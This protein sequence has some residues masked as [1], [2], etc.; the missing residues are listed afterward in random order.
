MKSLIGRL[1]ARG[2][3]L[4]ELLVVIAIIGILAGMLLPAVA[5]ARERARRTRCMSN[6]SQIGKAMKLYSMDHDEAFPT[7]FNPGLLGYDVDNPK[8]YHCPSDRHHQIADEFEDMTEQYCSYNLV[9]ESPSGTA[10][11]EGSKSTTMHACDKDGEN[12]D[13]T[14]GS[15]GGNHAGDGGNV[16][17]IDGS[18]SWIPVA[19]WVNYDGTGLAPWGTTNFSFSISG[20]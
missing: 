2:F 3:T 19:D 12:E 18:V 7:N 9:Y 10:L 6:L 13:V 14:A 16:L 20:E 1:R 5:A 8:L 11:T 4:I 17:Y 15:F